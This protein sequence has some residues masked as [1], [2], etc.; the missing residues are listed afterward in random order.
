MSRVLVIDDHPIVLAGCR[1]LLEDLG[2]E[3]V[4][5]ARDI[6][7]GYRLYRRHRPEVA[8]VDLGMGDG[9]LPGLALIRRL[10]QQDARLGILAFSMHGDPV[11]VARALEAGA[12]GY[13]LK[14]TMAEDFAEAYEKVRAGR[15]YLGHEVAVQVA[16]VRSGRERGILG[17]LTARE[18]QTLAL[19]AEGKSYGDIA[20]DMHVSYKTV[21]NT[22]SQLKAKLGVSSLA[23]LIRLGLR[24]VSTGT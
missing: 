16:L 12:T 2:V 3:T 8:I 6:V 13:L 14:D 4:L 21:A 7:S 23:G 19:L 18:I 5:E 9:G 24:H 22:I 15:P 20:L 17:D 11:V 10:R 1:R